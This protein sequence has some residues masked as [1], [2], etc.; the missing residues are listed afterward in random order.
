M[1]FFND[2]FFSSAHV[3]ELL[4]RKKVNGAAMTCAWDELYNP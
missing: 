4:H 2:V 3:L 1:I